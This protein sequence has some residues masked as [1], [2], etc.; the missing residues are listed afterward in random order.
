MM[1]LAT[2]ADR[3]VLLSIYSAFRRELQSLGVVGIDQMISDYLAYLDGF[4]W[5]AVRGKEGFDVVFVDELHLFNRQER[6]I[7][8]YLT[9]DPN[10]SP[11]VFL[12]Y[13]A[14]QSPRDT[15]MGVGAGDSERYNV[16]SAIGLGEIE[17]IELLDVFRYTPEIERLLRVVD[18]AFPAID[19]DEDWPSYKGVS[20][21]AGGPKPIL[22]E[23]R[24]LK[25]L[26]DTVFQRA[27]SWT[28]KA[29]SGRKVAVLCMSEDTFQIYLKAG[30]HKDL[31]LPITSRD[32]LANIR[33]ARKRF[34][35]SRP[36]YVAGLQFEVVLLIDVNESENPDSENSVGAKRRF[37]SELYL[38]A[39]RAEKHL[40]VFA[41]HERGGPAKLLEVAVREGA[42][43][44]VKNDSL[45][46][47]KKLW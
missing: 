8:Q 38:G 42:I 43:V 26:Y 20:R 15:F 2:R 36:E 6:M 46:H 40:E 24:D 21:I 35:L 37:V 18:Q 33:Y 44:K 39:S 23:L 47:P 11:A 10:S 1:N 45:P 32:E 17:K 3:E 9:R 12:A 16:W 28:N 19:L 13:D 27:A 34:V 5:D 30:Q 22:V 31:F 14:K 25:S 7:F 29:R 41:C 4:R